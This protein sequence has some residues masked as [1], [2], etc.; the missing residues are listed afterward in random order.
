MVLTQK[1]KSEF[2]SGLVVKYILIYGFITRWFEKHFHL[3]VKEYFNIT[4]MHLF[5][6]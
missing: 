2:F 6:N 3:V 5:T 1:M 4:K